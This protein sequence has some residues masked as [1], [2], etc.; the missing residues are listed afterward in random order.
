MVIRTYIDKDNTIIKSLLA[1][2]GRNEIAQL[3]YGGDALVTNYTRHL[4]YF[5]VDDLQTKYN[6]GELGDLSNLTHTLKMTNTSFFDEDLLSQKTCEGFQRAC[7]FDLT[8]FRVNKYWDEGC[9]YDYTQSITQQS[10]E[11]TYVEGASNWVSSTSTIDWDDPGVYSGSPSAITV[12]TQSFDKGNENLEM[13][14]TNEVNSLITGGTVNYG[15]GISFDRDLELVIKAESQYVGFFTKETQTYYE[16]F[17]ETLYDNPIRDD[18]NKFYKG[19]TNK[20]YLYVNVGGQPTNLDN[21]PSVIIKDEDDVTYTAI[22]TGQTVQ[23]T[24]GV[25]S[26][27]FSIP[28]SADDC[29]I[30]SDIWGDL[31]VNGVS[32]SDVTLDFEVRDDENYFDIGTNDSNSLDYYMS[33]TGIKREEKIKRGDQRKVFV[34]ARKPFTTNETDVIDGLEYR[35]YIKEGTT[36]VNVIDWQNVNRTFNN[37]YFIIDTSWMIPNIYYIDVKLTSNLEVKT[38]SDTMKFK[39][40]NQID[41]H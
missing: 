23:V 29:V 38:Y 24:K 35:L 41:L 2:T 37:N 1:N 18:R 5:D 30:Y 11:I 15:Y 21:N 36:E 28:T 13:D 32:R 3:Y 17:V 6:N 19:K 14:I 16:P 39:I 8:L 34:T 4:I 31:N 7:S 10:D 27:E 9:G 12:T 20:L 22:T 33:V 40:V 25:Y 26:V